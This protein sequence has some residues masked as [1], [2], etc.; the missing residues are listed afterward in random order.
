MVHGITSADVILA[1]GDILSIDIGIFYRGYVGDT[2][3]T[4]MVGEVSEEKERL[5]R[6]TRESL[7]EGIKQARAGNRLSDISHAVQ[8]HVE[9]NGFSVVRDFVGHGVGQQMHEDPQIPNFGQPGRGPRLEPGIVLAIEPMVNAG[10]YEVK[11]LE[12]GWTAVTRDGRPSA[13]AE[14][15]IAITSEEAQI[16]SLLPHAERRHEV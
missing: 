11:V 7:Y 12:D 6:V 4:F 5:I 15:S 10:A 13:H 3:A 9:K 8:A 16:L 14:H 2:A 1:E